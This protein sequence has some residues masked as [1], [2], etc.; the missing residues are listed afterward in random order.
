MNSIRACEWPDAPAFGAECA[1]SHDSEAV[2]R[3]MATRRS[4]TA[5]FL[6]EPGPDEQTLTAILTAASRVPDH[7]KM[8]PFR[9]IV[10]A[11]DAREKGGELLARALSA[12]EPDAGPEKVSIERERFTRAPLTVAVVS[13]TD[14]AH[15]TPEW[16]QILTAGAVC[17]NLLIA[18]LG[19]GFAAQWLTEWYAY[20]PLVREGFGL[21]PE[22]ERFAGFVYL[23]TASAPPKER[24]RPLLNDLISRF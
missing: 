10:I 22:T 13:R 7:R 20:D 11:G 1:P 6:T 9:F 8:V 2:R 21:D 18:A 3:L 15:M 19:S 12:N 16:E 23:G 14:K 5:A 17:Q 24:R 4:T